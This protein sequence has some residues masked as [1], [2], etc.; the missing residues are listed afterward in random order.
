MKNI[1]RHTMVVLFAQMSV[2]DEK[3]L[4]F[5]I[6]IANEFWMTA[7]KNNSELYRNLTKKLKKF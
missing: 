6:T 1:P 7:R 4:T 5:P 2:G 3:T